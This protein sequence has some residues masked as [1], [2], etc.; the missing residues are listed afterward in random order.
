VDRWRKENVVY[1]HLFRLMK[2]RKLIFSEGNLRQST[3]L[4]G[5]FL[6]IGDILNVYII[7]NRIFDIVMFESKHLLFEQ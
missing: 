5:L 6:F 3:R 2:N 7:D 1:V 4:D